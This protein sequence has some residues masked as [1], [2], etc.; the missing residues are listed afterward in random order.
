M[1]KEEKIENPTE[2]ELSKK[3]E[4][5]LDEGKSEAFSSIS[6]FD[7]SELLDEEREKEYFRKI[8]AALFV[9]GRW[10]SIQE[11]V[12]LTNVNPILLKMLITRLKDRYED[13]ESALYIMQRDNLWKMDIKQEYHNMTGKLASGNSEFTKAEQSTLAIIAYK[14][15]IK[16]SVIVNIRGN[17]AY[18][19]VHKFIQLN[20][21][22][23]K[24]VGH[25]K[26]LSLNDEFYNY[27]SLQ[28][29][30]E[31]EVGELIIENKPKENP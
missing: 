14:Q 25:T 2:E 10:L 28:P 24:R 4:D 5:N 31:G 18:D 13:K 26:E 8:E 1:E 16:Q 22:K 20:L 27:F 21:I 15:P 6:K 29:D 12:M 30:E 9:A 19:H 23:A 11:L 7:N 17:K 3:N